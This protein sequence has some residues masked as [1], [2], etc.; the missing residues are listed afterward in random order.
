MAK[1]TQA[2][3][4]TALN[5]QVKATLTREI[6]NKQRSMSQLAKMGELAIK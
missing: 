2:T 5:T 6:E 3:D 1:I 4:R